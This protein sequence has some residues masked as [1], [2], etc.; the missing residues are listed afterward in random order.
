M[1]AGLSLPSLLRSASALV[2]KWGIFE[3]SWPGPANALL[4]ATFQHEHH[5]ITVAGFYDGSG[6]HRI[7]F[8]PD[9]EG[10]WSYMTASESPDLNGKS[11]QF[12]CAKPSQ[13]NHGPVL[14]R[15]TYGFGYADGTPFYQF[16]TTCYAWTHQG[17]ELEQ[18]TL[19]SL[20][21]SPF[22]KIRMCVFP[23]WY[24]YNRGEPDLH[25]FLKPDFETFNPSFFQHLEKRIAQLGAMGIEADVI[26]FHPYD[27]WGYSKMPPDVDDRYLR[28]V[29]A[30]LSAHRNV[31]WSVANEWDLVK[32][33]TPSD[34]DRYFRII[35]EA[36]PYRRLC[37]IHH[38]RVMYDHSKPRVTHA[39]IQGD[40]FEKITEWREQWK[41]PILFD[42]CKY[43]GNIPKRWGDISAREMV[44]RFWLGTA[45]GAWVGHGET[46][47][48]RNDVLW[49]SKGGLLHGE[50]PSRIAFLRRVIEQAGPMDPFPNAYYPTL[51]G[52][53]YLVYFSYHQPAEFNI[54]L[55]TATYRAE[56]ID[57]WEMKS[58]TLPGTY[59][60]KVKLSLPGRPYMALRFVKL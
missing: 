53:G 46:Y 3:A 40:E 45:M 57:P 36:D 6:T 16:G 1:A 31:W 43:E 12:V 22:N 28:H 37:S 13:G 7:R 4:S 60:A 30:R 42:E 54:D 15:N 9:A 24:E 14:T 32:T 58:T 23:K 2:E 21:I 34:W 56:L 27:K 38:S 51:K 52:D 33:K 29:I 41:K 5:R 59:T 8:M 17:E 20:R 50:S 10:E 11:G 39:S 49:W 25:P 18:Q 19:A 55:G 47:L 26:L 35:Q 48:D 44:H